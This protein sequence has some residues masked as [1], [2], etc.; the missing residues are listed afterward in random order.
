MKL[1]LLDRDGVINFSP[2]K[3]YVMS[4]S[5]MILLPQAGEAISKLNK[6]GIK[7]A[8]ITNQSIIGQ[9][10]LSLQELDEIHAH[11]QNL[12]EKE[13]AWID[14]IF[15]CPDSP[16]APT[17]RRKPNPGMLLEA[18]EFFDAIPSE[19]PFVGDALS[20]LEA[21]FKAGCPRHLVRTGHGLLTEQTEEIKDFSPVTIHEDLS[22][23]VQHLLKSSSKNFII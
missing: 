5:E 23:A 6:Q 2:G 13:N 7:V 8:V 12:L 3:S 4:P 22:S 9:G 20:D 15:F 10:D 18:L 11:L 17:Y 21:A 16:Q 14:K 19:T 1:V